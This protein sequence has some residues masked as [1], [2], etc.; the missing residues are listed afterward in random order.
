M[1]LAVP[2]TAE[3]SDTIIAQLES[4]L[5][6]TIPLLP[7]SFSRVLA[8]VLAGVFILLYK[9]GGF[10]FL[11]L[12]VAHATMRET[13][14]N[15]KTIRPLV[16]W[17]RLIGVGD[18]IDA[19]LAELV[20]TVTVTNQVGNLDGGAQLVRAE[21]GFVYDSVAAVALS[22]PTVQITIKAGSDQ[23]GNGGV[24]AVGNLQPGDIVSFANPLPNVQ[25]D[26]IVL[27]QAVTAA[28]AETVEA[29]RARILRRF[30]RKPQGGA[31][32]DY[33]EWSDGVA[34]I[35]NAYPYAGN[36]GE[37]DVYIEATVASSG[38][39]DGIPTGAQLI[40]V[41][42]A[43]QLDVAGL[44][45]NRP[46]NAAVNV[47]P[48]TRSGFDVVIS[49]LVA[50]DLPTLKTSIETG[51]DEYLRSREPFIVGLSVLPRDDRITVAALGGLVDGI[52]SAAGGTCTSVGFSVDA[53]GQTAYTLGN[54]EKAKL[55]IPAT[56]I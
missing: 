50:D 28:D 4:S 21:T 7:K 45:T 35:L 13:I 1:S 29:Y 51:L 33:Q 41:N 20:V 24:G 55:T 38:S 42:D 56:Y 37:V 5:S 10:I 12:F 18:P 14:V 49:G 40:A 32:A 3:I 6:E 34:G 31:Y 26:A 22:A 25:R 15:G 30:Q 47:L 44:A 19:T 27:S 46:V 48:I 23:D 17:G 2:T 53:V 36:P 16:E 9:Y 11:Q 39:P 43:I 52:V 8:K 54:G